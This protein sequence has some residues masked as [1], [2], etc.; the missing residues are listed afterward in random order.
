MQILQKH[1]KD[2]LVLVV[3]IS[4]IYLFYKSLY[5]EIL[6]IPIFIIYRKFAAKEE[7]SK[8]KDKL[9]GQFKDALYS[10]SAALRAGY[11]VE[12]ALVESYKEMQLMYGDDAPICSELNIMINQMNL[13]ANSEKV[14]LD[15]AGR[16]GLEST[17]TFAEVF[18]IARKS[19][20]DMVEIIK[21]TAGD[22]ASKIETKNEISIMVTSKKFEQNIMSCMPVGIILYISLT[23]GG[24]LDPL[25]GNAAGI[26]IMT[27]CLGLYGFSFY[28]TRKIL[29][30]KV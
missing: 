16:T 9:D 28:L 22:I 1:G 12:N 6:V 14:F 18:A 5:A 2:I 29:N 11:S 15:F 23:S 21:K 7:E 3:I 24:M 13:G 25:Y 26:A 27:V 8:Y 20:G 4:V 30:I 19:G 17:E 10:L